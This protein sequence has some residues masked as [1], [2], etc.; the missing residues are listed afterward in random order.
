MTTRSVPRARSKTELQV[1]ELVRR[2][3]AVRQLS[4]RNLADKC[5]FSPSFISQVELGQASPSIASTERIA[6]ALGVSLGEFF[7]AASPSLP[8]IIRVKDRPVLQ[9]QWSHAKIEVLG[10]ASEDS[11]LESML[12][13]LKAGGASASRPYTR[14]AEQLAVV[15]R[16]TV[17]LQLEE[18]MYV[19]GEGDAVSI[20]A[21]TR[22]CWNNAARKQVQVFIVTVRMNH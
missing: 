19:L 20:P 17:R 22:H 1:G 5:G 3:R 2:F 14:Q 15:F 11:R 8:A 18:E 16:G 4:V 12:M 9:S 13:T 7:R 10:P 6:S 21:G